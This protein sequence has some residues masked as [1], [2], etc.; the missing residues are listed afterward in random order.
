MIVPNQAADAMVAVAQRRE[1]MSK[2][3]GDALQLFCLSRIERHL[4]LRL[5]EKGV[6]RDCLTYSNVNFN[7]PE[8]CRIKFLL[9]S[10]ERMLRSG[11][12]P[13]R[14]YRMKQTVVRLLWVGCIRYS[15]SKLLSSVFRFS[16]CNSMFCLERVTYFCLLRVCVL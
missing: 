12:Q 16:C 13:R 9:S 8:S 2:G 3:H 5:W 6:Y 1:S 15:L 7:L 14:L 4:I 11:S 10:F